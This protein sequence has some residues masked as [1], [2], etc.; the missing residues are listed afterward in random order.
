MIEP[1]ILPGKD[2]TTC[3]ACIS[4]RCKHRNKHLTLSIDRTYSQGDFLMKFVRYVRQISVLFFD[5]FF[6]RRPDA[7]NQPQFSFCILVM[8]GKGSVK[9]GR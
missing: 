1:F 5:E 8:V 6:F 9:T 3:K 2:D 4:H 7:L